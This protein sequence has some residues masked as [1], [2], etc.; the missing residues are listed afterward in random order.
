MAKAFCIDRVLPDHLEPVARAKAAQ[1]HGLDRP[2]PFELALL[3]R[4]MWKPGRTLRI[5]FLDGD[6]A[7][8][9]KIKSYA[10]QWLKHANIR[11][12]WVDGPEAEIRISFLQDGYWSALGTDAL[13]E[14]F[15]PPGEP[16]MNFDSFSLATPESEYSR[17]V[18]HEFG[19]ALGCIHEHQSPAAGIKWDKEVVYRDLGGPPNNWSKA[20]VDHNVFNAYSKTITQFTTF[21][22]E[23]IMLYAFP[24][25]WTRDGM[26][27]PSNTTLSETDK[28]FIGARY[29]FEAAA[30]V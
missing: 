11:F 12:D 26:Q 19:H 18:L 10:E 6:S 25:E 2:S 28:A 23:S 4:K 15:F 14:E 29:P 16:T 8:H 3:T 21:D 30:G 17:V 9:A 24:S 27:F 1:E 7:V 22:P 5:C 13:V 20:T